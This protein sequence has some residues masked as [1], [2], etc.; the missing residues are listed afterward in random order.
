M[1]AARVAR[2]V[3]LRRRTHAERKVGVVLFNFP[4]NAGAAGTAAFLSVFE[5]LFNLLRALQRDGYS[6]DVP[7]DVAKVER[8]LGELS[9][10]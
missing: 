10:G 8:L 4:P 2:W 3:A 9:L 6:V 5:S 1:L 7:A